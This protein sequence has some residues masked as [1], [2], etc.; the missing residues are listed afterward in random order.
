M[1]QVVTVGA[2]QVK[3]LPLLVTLAY[4]EGK[5]WLARRLGISG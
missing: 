3:G 2:E 1:K 4:D 5:P